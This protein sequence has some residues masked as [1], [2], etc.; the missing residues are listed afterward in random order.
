MKKLIY[1]IALTISPTV[2]CAEDCQDLLEPIQQSLTTSEASNYLTNLVTAHQ[3]ELFRCLGES[4]STLPHIP[5]DSFLYAHGTVPRFHRAVKNFWGGKVFFSQGEHITLL[6]V[7]KPTKSLTFAAAVSDGHSLLDGKP[8]II[9][10]YRIDNTVVGISR[11]IIRQIRD[12]MRQ[13]HI[14]D[15]PI[16]LY[17]GRALLRKYGKKNPWDHQASYRNFVVYF[18]LDAS[19]HRQEAMPGWIHEKISDPS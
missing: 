4:P 1:A 16:P 19:D 8:A 5:T 2:Y 7:I 15:G 12:E 17:L 6:N 14:G 10:D 13:I 9:L 18:V 3:E 11:P